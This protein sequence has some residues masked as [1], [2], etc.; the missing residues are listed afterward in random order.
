MCDRGVRLEQLPAYSSIR[1]FFGEIIERSVA[2]KERRG[3][4][5]V[6][7]VAAET[8]LA[9]INCRARRR[10]GSNPYGSRREQTSAIA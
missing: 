3:C 1:V 5:L 4:V 8:Y 10:P 2:D 6:K 9:R 7:E